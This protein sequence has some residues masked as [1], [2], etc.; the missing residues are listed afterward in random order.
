MNVEEE[1]K[2]QEEEINLPVQNEN[3]VLNQNPIQNQNIMNDLEN[4]EI[5]GGGLEIPSLN[6]AQQ[7]RIRNLLEG[8]VA[9]RAEN[10]E[11]RKKKKTVDMLK[12]EKKKTKNRT[13]DENLLV[14]LIKKKRYIG[15]DMTKLKGQ[16]SALRPN[17]EVSDAR[18]NFYMQF[19]KTAVDVKKLPFAKN[20]MTKKII[21]SDFRIIQLD[22]ITSDNLFWFCALRRDEGLSYAP[23]IDRIDS[24]YLAS[25]KFISFPKGSSITERYIEDFEPNISSPG[26]L[27]NVTQDNYEMT[28][29]EITFNTFGKEYKSYTIPNNA[30]VYYLSSMQKNEVIPKLNKSKYVNTKSSLVAGVKVNKKSGDTYF[31]GKITLTDFCPSTLTP[32]VD[33][34]DFSCLVCYAID[35]NAFINSIK[36]TGE[37]KDTPNFFYWDHLASSMELL[38]ILIL[39]TNYFD[40]RDNNVG[41]NQL[42]DCYNYYQENKKVF[43][44]YKSHF[45]LFRKIVITFLDSF[46]TRA[47]I[48]KMNE[49]VKDC[50]KFLDERSILVTFSDQSNLMKTF[51]TLMRSRANMMFNFLTFEPERY[52][53]MILQ[54]CSLAINPDSQ[55]ESLSE[56]LRSTCFKVSQL[57]FNGEI[58]MINEIRSI[59]SFLG[60]LRGGREVGAVSQLAE[61]LWVKALDVRN[62]KERNEREE[63][64]LKTDG[65]QLASLNLANALRTLLDA[66]QSLRED[67]NLT[68]LVNRFGYGMER[69][70]VTRRNNPL[71]AYMQNEE[72]NN[73]INL[74]VPNQQ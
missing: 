35:P 8:E 9:Q 11:R 74:S 60:T 10:I 53:S 6:V 22:R 42:Y 7:E 2:K 65:S 46:R 40:G 32:L 44:D 73:I 33:N 63:R 41:K 12:R 20:L 69:L 68:D 71:A 34:V 5:V 57:L 28:E 48:D 37:F 18:Y 1:E 62:A 39:T 36:S 21:I 30:R 25:N 17:E 47:S 64:K 51:V 54:A 24:I 50:N 72:P 59:N 55:I 4:G 43:N 66:Q 14:Q 67:R 52:I 56:T 23:Y 31:S 45:I 13:S 16:Y 70:G 49:I 26:W 19:L 15:N 3:L 58:P 61:E 29:G 27:L 38:G